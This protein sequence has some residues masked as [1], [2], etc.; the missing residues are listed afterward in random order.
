MAHNEIRFR[1]ARLEDAAAIAALSGELGYPSSDAGTAARLEAI[2]R[3]PDHCLLLAV[4]ASAQ[5]IAWAHAY[6]ARRLT[7]EPHVELGGLIVAWQQRGF[8]IGRA[9]LTQIE[10]WSREQ[11]AQFV[12]VRSNVVRERAHGFYGAAGYARS[13]TS[14]VFEKALVAAEAGGS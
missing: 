13:K 11:G 7:S 6:V 3:H 1:S 4:D 9:L 14:H 10:D 2:L 5:P 8:G 12:R